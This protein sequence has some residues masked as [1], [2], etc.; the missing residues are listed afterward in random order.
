MNHSKE[1]EKLF[2]YHYDPKKQPRFDVLTE[3]FKDA[4]QIIYS[5]CR[6]SKERDIAIQKLQE[7]RMWANASIALED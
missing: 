3:I 2:T 5:H 4:A 7:S 1:V 6:D